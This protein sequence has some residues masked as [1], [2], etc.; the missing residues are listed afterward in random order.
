MACGAK[1]CHLVRYLPDTFEVADR[2]AT[3]FLNE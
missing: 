3:K 1:A 2:S